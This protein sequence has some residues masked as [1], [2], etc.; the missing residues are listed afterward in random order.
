MANS[1]LARGSN[2][3]RNNHAQAPTTYGDFVA[4]H[5]PL[6]TEAGEPLE[7][8]NWLHV[9]EFKFG[10]LCCMETQKIL[11][12]AQQLR[13]DACA[14][15]AIYIATRPMN[16]QVL[17]DEFRE[18][19]CTHHILAS[20][21]RRKHKEFID[22]KQG[23]RFVHQYSK[24]FNH[25]AQYALEQ[26]DTDETKKDCFMNGLSTEL[27]EC[28]ALSMGGTFPDFISNTIIADDKI[29]VHKESRKR[30]VVAASSSNAPSK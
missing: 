16:Y 21:M 30:K 10:L 1:T 11:F 9:I 26:V 29:H 7:A 22:L 17:W 27:Q 14:W 6:F 18:A 19:F 5:P 13:G 28:L 4:T 12:A 20:V 15:W 25:L 24:Q 2:G 23:G 3:A 8:D